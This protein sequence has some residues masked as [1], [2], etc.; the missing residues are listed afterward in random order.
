LLQETD[1]RVAMVARHGKPGGHWND[2]CALVTLRQRS[3]F[4]GVGSMPLGSER[5]D[6]NVVNQGLCELASGPE[7]SGYFD[8]EMRQRLLPSGRV[9]Y[10]P[11]CDHLGESRFVSML[12]GE[13]TQVRVARKTVDATFFGISVPATHTPESPW[14]DGVELVPCRPWPICKAG[15]LA[16]LRF[17]AA[18]D[19]WRRPGGSLR[20]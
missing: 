3:A 6:A 20:R 13:E 12:S 16:N 15:C 4:Y 11:L 7:V 2:A 19:E 9:S 18:P 14:A 5:K 17:S 10:H 1:A 8:A